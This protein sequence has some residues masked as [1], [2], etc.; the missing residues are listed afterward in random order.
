VASEATAACVEWVFAQ[1]DYPRVITLIRPENEPSLA[2]ARKIGMV[3]RGLTL[4]A[5]YEHKVYAIDRP[6]QELSLAK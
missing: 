3:E 5:G 6:G 4:F 1:T 2:V